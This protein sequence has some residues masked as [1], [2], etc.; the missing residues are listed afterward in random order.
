VVVFPKNYYSKVIIMIIKTV[1]LI[2]L[3]FSY[4]W[5]LGQNQANIQIDFDNPLH[6]WDGFGV[7]YVETRHT[8]D[9]EV[10]PQDYGGFKYLNDEQRKEII[11]LIFGEDGLKPALVKVFADPFLEP[12][13]D[14]DDPY[15]IDMTGFD[16][17]TTTQWIRYFAEEGYKKTKSWGGDLVFFAGIYG[18]PG[19]TTKQKVLRGRDLDPKYR[20]EV[21]EY[22]ISW[23]KYLRDQ[24][25]LP[26]KY[27]SMH[28]EGEGQNRWKADGGDDPD[29]YA[30]D[31]NMW[32][33]SHQI[34]DF[35]KYA[36]DILY[37]NNMLDVKISS[38][39]TQ[40]WRHFH[41]YQNWDSVDVNI[42][43]EI[44][45]DQEAMKNLGLI[46]SHGFLKHY[47]CQGVDILKKHNPGLHAW[48]TSYTWGKMDVDFVE[49][50]RRLIYDVKNNGLI[51][52]ATV[53]H[54]YES[55]KLS[56]PR[57]FR[58]SSNANSPIKTNDGKVEV[59]KAYYFFKQISRAGQPSMRVA[60][61]NSDSEDITAIAFE[62]NITDNPDAFTIINNAKEDIDVKI[63]IQGHGQSLYLPFVTSDVGF[64]DRNYQELKKIE[65][66]GNIIVYKAPARSATTFYQLN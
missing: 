44:S 6:D 9:Y 21:A 31:Y 66:S 4:G 30:H 5:V 42:A 51:P 18:P 25:Q 19:W 12:E 37:A 24:Y 38:G 36:D 48:T 2:G 35:I 39:E 43:E 3:V 65:S 64:S 62:K 59:T 40:T 1:F 22:I 13:N 41:S 52:W 10:F 29:M 20:L 47:D 49:E 7:N 15:H 26:V 33:P 27:I 34:V 14:N 56:P 53:H 63:Q 50:S 57:E 58:N 55:D 46:T 45:L 11:D 16:H 17:E 28:N 60:Y 8:R 54:D 61:V 32:W 23:A